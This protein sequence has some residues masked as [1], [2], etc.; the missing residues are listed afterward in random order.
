MTK[1]FDRVDGKKLHMQSLGAIS[2]IDYNKPGLCSYE[3]AALTARRMGLPSSD[4][5]QFYR[6]MIFNVL[7]VNQDD[8]VKNIS[9]LMDRNGIWTLSPAYD[10]TFACDSGNKWLLAHQMTINGEKSNILI[11]DMIVCGQN[12]DIKTFKCKRIIE[13]AKGAVKEWQTIA[14]SVEI[15]EKTISFINKEIESNNAK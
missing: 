8:H 10:V 5:E 3:M 14:H 4:T 2:H 12:M 11:N 6:R 13:E 15:R 7:A 1:R 9:F